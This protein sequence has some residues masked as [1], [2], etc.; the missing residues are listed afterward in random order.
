MTTTTLTAPAP[1]T[2]QPL[3]AVDAVLCPNCGEP[4]VVAWRTD[5]SST[6]G[7]IEHVKIS[8]QAGHRY[9]MPSEGLTSVATTGTNVS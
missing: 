1:T 2:T 9:F 8:C 5:L 3:S 6:E 4:A 7:S